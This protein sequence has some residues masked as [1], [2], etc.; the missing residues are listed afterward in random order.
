[1][2]Y[3]VGLYLYL[4]GHCCNTVIACITL[5]CTI[6]S[7]LCLYHFVILLIILTWEP[8][9]ISIIF[10]IIFATC[11]SYVLYGHEMLYTKQINK[12]TN[13]PIQY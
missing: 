5:L 10:I 13:K 7:S 2:L 11:A 3:F 4:F 1:M 6:L 12:Q 8:T 9:H